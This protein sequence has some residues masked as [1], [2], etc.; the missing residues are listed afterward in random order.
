MKTLIRI[1]S[2]ALVAVF[3]GSCIKDE[4]N[5]LV[6]GED[7]S[8]QFR[9][10]APPNG[11]DTRAMSPADE[12]QVNTIDVLAFYEDSN[13]DFR[14]RY[15]A[16]QTGTEI[17]D[18]R[19]RIITV[20]AQGLVERQQFVIL[21]NAS[22]ELTAA[23]II[24]NEKLE[25]AMAKIIDSGNG[26]WPARNNG[27]SQIKHIPMY[28]KT[29]PRVVT[30]VTG[31]I[32]SAST[33]YPLLRMVA[34]I[35][36]ELHSNV[37]NFVLNSGWLFN[38]QKAGY[39]AYD[40]SNYNDAQQRVA[41]A[42][43]PPSLYHSGDPVVEPNVKYL[44]QNTGIGVNP[45]GELIR[46]MYT[47]EAP[48]YGSADRN[49]GF[50]IVV[51]GFFGGS[52]TETYYRINLRGAG[53][54]PEL[55]SSPILRNHLYAVEVQKVNAAG[56]SNPLD[57]YLGT[58]NLVAEVMIWDQ[59]DIDIPI[60]ST[61]FLNVD[62]DQFMLPHVS[63][64]RTVGVST[65]FPTG[66]TAVSD[67][68]GWLGVSASGDVLTLNVSANITSAIRRGVVSVVAGHLTKYIYVVQD[69][70]GGGTQ[71][72]N[73]YVGAFWRANETGER[74]IRIDHTGAWSATVGWYDIN[75]NPASG[76]GIIFEAGDSPDTGITWNA[77]TEN[78]GN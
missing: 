46:T 73:T 62:R 24:P 11:T 42:A 4:D 1:I 72:P 69:V 19:S 2:L 7:I 5:P 10:D 28:A 18:D 39:V 29:A 25:T 32:P 34:R 78:P 60:P 52:S 27:S 68:P 49:K 75:W 20:T 44:A 65:D 64:S 22:A 31:I 40:F 33:S 77:L 66:W 70:L 48:A 71:L 74:I 21:A 14:Y 47:Y 37:T 43:V 53:A 23:N 9:L 17:V 55:L 15:K 38:Y 8:L 30:S 6:A 63:G 35:D 16:V 51:G 76:D 41:A 13:G 59:R 61:Y 57:A 3:V 56:A 45:R 67:S 36:V 58:S 50:A 26:E 54:S 12:L